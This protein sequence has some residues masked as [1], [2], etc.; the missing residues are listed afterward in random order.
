MRCVVLQ[1]LEA[2]YRPNVSSYEGGA[3]IYNKD[4]ARVERKIAP[5]RAKTTM[6]KR[7]DPHPSASTPSFKSLAIFTGQSIVAHHSRR[8]D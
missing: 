3:D 1:D 4:E 2:P 8:R 7:A 5:R 6:G